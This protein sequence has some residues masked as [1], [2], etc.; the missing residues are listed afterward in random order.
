MKKICVY[1]GSSDSVH[2]DYLAAA[3]QAGAT[4]AQRGLT[5]VYGGG[6]TGLMGAVADGALDAGGD[7]IGVIVESMNTPALAH[8]G[9][10]RLEVSPRIHER[11][12][13][14]Y[15]LADGY[16]A[17]PGGFGTFDELFET[18]TWGQIG[19]HSKPVGLLNARRYFDR[20]LSALDLAVEEGFVFSEHRNAIACDI[21][22][23]RLLDKMNNHSYPEDAMRRWMRQNQ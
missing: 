4:L 22:P 3:R 13:R 2:P 14:M 8:Y 16:I 20:L 21:D 7:V 11:K 17:L 9:L 19:E 12:A 18:L 10:T 15:E 1:C 5:V 6:K 23:G